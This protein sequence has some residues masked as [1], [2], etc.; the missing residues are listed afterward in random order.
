MISSPGLVADLAQH[1]VVN[2]K[3][4]ITKWPEDV[5]PELEG[6]FTCGYYDG[7]GSLGVKPIYRWSVISGN[8]EFLTVMQDHI[9]AR[10]GVKVGG[11]YVDKRHDAAWSIVATGE[12]VRALDAWVHG[13]C[14][15]W[16]GSR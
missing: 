14:P 1:G 7:D 3:S 16:T 15:D 6:S 2:A 5:P 13:A 10:T 11:P 12:R 9:L 4:L 8:P